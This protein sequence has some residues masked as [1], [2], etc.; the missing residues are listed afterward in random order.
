MEPPIGVVGAT[1]SEVMEPPIGVVDAVAIHCMTTW[2]KAV[3]KSRFTWSDHGTKPNAGL[4]YIVNK[5]NHKDEIL[6]CHLLADQPWKARHGCIMSAWD[7]L[8]EN[9]LTEKRE[10]ACVFEGTS[11]VTIHKQYEQVSLHLGKTWTQEKEQRIQEEASEDDELDM[12]TQRTTKQLIKQGIMDLYKEFI[13][14]K[15]ELESEKQEEKQQDAHGK[16]VA[17][18]ISDT[19]LG[20]L[21]LKSHKTS[22]KEQSTS[23]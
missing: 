23:S 22:Y 7:S 11:V 16:M 12:D 3:K 4:M 14:H 21:R 8:L 6:I 13:Q 18:R 5:W 10:R 2:R 20:R 19:A 1:G 17:I 9:L 15:E